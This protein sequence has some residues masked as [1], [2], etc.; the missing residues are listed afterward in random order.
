MNTKFIELEATQPDV[1]LDVLFRSCEVLYVKRT[2][3]SI[4]IAFIDRPG[5]LVFYFRT[6]EESKRQLNRIH[7]ELSK[8]K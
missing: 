8:R 3:E 6:E 5:E 4:A 2:G 7:K 1:P